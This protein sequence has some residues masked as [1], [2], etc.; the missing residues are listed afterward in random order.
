[1]EQLRALLGLG[2]MDDREREE[3]MRD[4][5]DPLGKDV[6]FGIPLYF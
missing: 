3:R 6:V 4:A 2:S 5:V 1:M